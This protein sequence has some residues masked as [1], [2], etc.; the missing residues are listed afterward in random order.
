MIK[1]F[2]YLLL[3]WF[4]V[5]SLFIFVPSFLVLYSS[6]SYTDSTS[7]KPPEFPSPPAL[8]PLEPLNT[9]LDAETQKRQVESLEIRVNAFTQQVNA[10]TQQVNAYKTYAENTGKS[11]SLEAYQTVVKDSLSSFLTT[12]LSALVAFAFA[13]AGAGLVDNYIRIKNG[14]EPQDIKLWE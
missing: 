2:Q 8:V 9:N 11:R 3:V 7:E 1:V 4:I 14:K 10:Y 13:K 6:W 12:L 5:I